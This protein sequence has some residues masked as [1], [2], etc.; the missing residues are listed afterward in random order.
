MLPAFGRL[1]SRIRLQSSR[2][3]HHY[4]RAGEVGD[5]LGQRHERVLLV[6]PERKFGQVE[7]VN[8]L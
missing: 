1:H 8:G 2:W 5:G 6:V 4:H 7:E 3:I